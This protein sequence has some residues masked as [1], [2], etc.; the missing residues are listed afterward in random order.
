MPD[1]L[2]TLPETAYWVAFYRAL[3]SERPDAIFRDPFARE[4]AGPRGEEIVNLLPHGRSYAWPMIVRTAVMDEII[5]RLAAGID[6]VLNLAA[7]LDA[8]PYR[9]ALPPGLRWIDVDYPATLEYKAR[10]LAKSTPRC[11]LERVPLDLADVAARRAL[12]ARVGAEARDVLV[13]TEGLVTYL[14]PEQVGA[15]A[16]DLAAQ[17]A[18]HRWM[19]DVAS[20]MVLRMISRVWGKHLDAGSATFRFGPEDAAAF[21][22]AHGWR[23]AEYHA[24][25]IDAQRLRREFPFAWLFRLLRPSMWRAETGRTNGPMSGVLLL[26]NAKTPA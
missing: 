10:V 21:Y 18:F 5:L 3:E 20:P 22:A 1:R 12:F 15:F 19:T 26:E 17:P 16:D 8:R 13:I 23:L 7:G 25:I 4:L 11:A 6:L 9:L 24:G 2:I 14:S